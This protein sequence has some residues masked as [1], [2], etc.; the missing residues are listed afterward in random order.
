MAMASVAV[1]G[2]GFA[3]LGMGYYLRR[4]GFED[5]LVFDKAG[6]PGGVW[7]ENRYPGAACDIPSH[8]YSFSFEPHFPWS[9]RFGPQSEILDY[10][11]HTARRH[12]LEPH[13][14]FGREVTDARFDAS[15]RAWTLRFADGSSHEAAYLV[16]AVG[17]LHRP[18]IPA[19]PGRERFAGR[20]FHSAQWDHDYDFRDRRVAVIGTGASAVQFAPAIARHARRMHV[21]Q[22]S[23]GWVLF[24]FDRAYRSWERRLLER[25]PLLHDLDRLRIFW[26]HEW[27]NSGILGNRVTAAMLRFACRMLL[28]R[29][30]R[31]PG[32]R[33]RLTPDF[34]F[35]CKRT[36]LS[37]EWLPFLASPRTEL[38][39]DSILGIEPAGV[40]TADGRLR[41]VDA[42]VYGTGFESTSFLAPMR[43]E[44][45]D[46]RELHE[47][48]S[49]GAEAYLGMAVAGFPNFF[50]LYGPNTNLGA[51]SIIYMLERQQRYI[52]RCLEKLRDA[53]LARI[54]VRAEAQRRFNEFLRERGRKTAFEAGCRSWYKTADGRN[55]NNWVGYC[56]QY[57]RAVSRPKFEDY[58]LDG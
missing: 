32:L 43:I 3:G 27:Y 33:R 35:G 45:A 24:K 57:G 41:E 47:A 8:L 6:E 52:V 30:V 39:T 36:L 12:G 2:A 14:R 25:I 42:I 20:A 15:R 17:Q 16:T 49:Q 29:Q 21:F 58:R 13:L 26:L 55:T 46:G 1:I 10:L 40:R 54:E 7:R 44:G 38:V 56:F 53:R 28:R 22:R 50:M 37:N 34:P 48:W 9:R 18:R 51:G 5:F 31:D 4:A 23:P 11:R 19:L